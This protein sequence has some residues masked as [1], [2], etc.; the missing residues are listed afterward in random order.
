[1]VCVDH[2]VAAL[3]DRDVGDLV[4]G[5]GDH[6]RVVEVPRLGLV[7]VREGRRVVVAADVALAEQLLGAVADA[8]ADVGV[9]HEALEVVADS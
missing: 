8:G 9:A 5:V 3:G 1:V 7:Q 4:G 2:V 6:D